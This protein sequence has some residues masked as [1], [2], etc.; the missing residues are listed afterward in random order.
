MHDLDGEL[1]SDKAMEFIGRPF[2]WQFNLEDDSKLYCTELLYVVLK[3]IDPSIKLNTMYMREIGRSIIPLDIC[4][5][6][7]YF[8]EI[9]YWITR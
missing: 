1:I 5:Q 3:K 6:T 7:E 2:D 8:T 9:G 4:S